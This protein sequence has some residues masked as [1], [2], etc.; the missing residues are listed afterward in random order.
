MSKGFSLEMNPCVY[1]AKY[2][3]NNIWQETYSEKPHLEKA[4]EDKLP[5]AKKEELLAKRNSFPELP[6]VN[7]TTQ[8]GF[9]CFE[10]LKAF[11]Q[12]GGG[13]KLF[14]PDENGK[15]METSMKGLLMPPFPVKMFVE[16]VKKITVSNRKLG[17]TPEY[18]RAWEKDDYVSGH[19]VYI[20]PFSYTEGGIGLN[21][22]K[23]PWVVI[24]TTQ[25]GAYF[26]SGNAKAT[27]TK[28]IRAF[29]GGTGWIKCDANYVTSTLAKMKAV[30]EGYME[31]VFLDAKEQKYFEEGSSCNI[32]FLLK[33]GTLVTPDLGDTV[34][35]G[36]TR[37]TILQIAQDMGIKTEE[38]RISVDEVF[39]EGKEAFVTGTASGVCHF[40]SLT[41]N[42]KTVIF[43]NRSM[44]PTTYEFLKTLKGIQ[45]GALPDKYGWMFDV[46]G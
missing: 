10:G 37:K 9:G 17:F 6:L 4:E 42:G 27:T 29:P 21:L 26:D 19:S 1:S 22:S 5:D 23:Y 46:N 40:E 11:P 28:M 34:L 38:R 25:V 43:G 41:H 18:D 20:R 2:T 32:F 3:E 13:L 31:A 14:R 12:K 35:P 39:S 8:Y 45:F 7:Y 30:S 15:R 24:V 16:A 33:N 36:I 44:G